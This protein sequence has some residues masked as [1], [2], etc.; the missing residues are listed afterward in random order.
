VIDVRIAQLEKLLLKD[1]A[2]LD[3]EITDLL[4]LIAW[5]L[6]KPGKTAREIGILRYVQN[7]LVILQA[8]YRKPRV[9]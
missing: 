7:E 9:L 1:R 3:R 2:K 4:A 8:L 6:A 5:E